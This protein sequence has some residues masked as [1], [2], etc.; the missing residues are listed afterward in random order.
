M[1]RPRALRPM[2]SRMPI[3][4]RVLGEPGGDDGTDD[5]GEDQYEGEGKGKH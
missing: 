2:A 3:R 1:V 5:C 4:S